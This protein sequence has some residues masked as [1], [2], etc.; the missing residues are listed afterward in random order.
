M[1]Q[2]EVPQTGIATITAAS[3]G[4]LYFNVT[5]LT[6]AAPPMANFFNLRVAKG[7]YGKIFFGVGLGYTTASS[8]LSTFMWANATAKHV[9]NSPAP[10]HGLGIPPPT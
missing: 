8:G 7:N 1:R 5:D 2:R 3:A 6:P 4:V 9:L 10:P